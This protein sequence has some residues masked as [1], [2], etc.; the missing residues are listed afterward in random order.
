MKRI[1]DHEE[2]PRLPIDDLREVRKVAGLLRN[3]FL[4]GAEKDGGETPTITEVGSEEQ[5]NA[6]MATRYRSGIVDGRIDPGDEPAPEWDPMEW[7]YELHVGCGEMCPVLAVVPYDC[8]AAAPDIRAA[9]AIAQA[10]G[11]IL[12][13]AA[14]VERLRELVEEAMPIVLWANA[15]AGHG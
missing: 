13:L 6:L 3:A 5:H 4:D 14:E 12:D 9:R 11:I 8:E 2:I 10:G 1:Y 15:R 7:H